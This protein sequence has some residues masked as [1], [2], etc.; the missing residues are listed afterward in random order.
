MHDLDEKKIY[1]HLCHIDNKVNN[2]NVSFDTSLKGSFR[3]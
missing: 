3:I 1:F 2:N